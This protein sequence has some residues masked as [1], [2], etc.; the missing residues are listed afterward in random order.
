VGRLVNIY[1]RESGGD[2]LRTRAG[3]AVPAEVDTVGTHIAQATD[4]SVG[5]LGWVWLPATH[6]Y[7]V[8]TL[9]SRSAIG[10]HR[11]AGPV[12]RVPG[13]PG[14]RATVVESPVEL[15][16]VLAS[17]L[18]SEHGGHPEYDEAVAAIRHEVASS[19]D[20]C[21]RYV[22]DRL[23][24]AG[25]VHPVD[26]PD[27][28][29][30]A[31][32]TLAFGHPFHPSPKL[33]DG[34]SPEDAGD[35]TPELSHGFPLWWIAA[36]P[37]LV[38]EER[39]PTAEPPPIPPEVMAAARPDW[40]LLPCHPWQARALTC[41]DDLAGALDDGTVR[42]LGP[43]GPDVRPTSSVRTVRQPDGSF[44][45]LSLDVRITNF[46]RHN[47]PEQVR[48][49]LDA[50]RI[51]TALPPRL[52]SGRLEVL[53]DTVYRALA[54]PGADALTTATAVLHRPGP[55]PAPTPAEPRQEAGGTP[56][57][58]ACWARRTVRCCTRQRT[59]GS[60]SPT[61]SSS[62]TSARS[63]PPSPRRRR[64]PRTSC[65]RRSP[66]SCGPRPPRPAGHPPTTCGRRCSARTCRPRPT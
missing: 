23:A 48:R 13:R 33:A 27:P 43:L 10:H 30:A 32:A 35:Y 40:L 18:L 31:E 44:W 39:L 16:G 9:A 14:G 42:L 28:T 3:G 36:P 46:V 50:G 57:T 8:A 24:D 25:R 55:G 54:L 56:P 26:A 47:T 4:G 7:L 63:S 64:W 37:D 19:V 15:A 2:R 34:F 21:A 22:A 1:L 49:T 11:L 45:K 20:R 29:L 6:A 62:T 12:W 52:R 51:I 5:Q 61:T 53:P 38:A 65:G 59:P 41:R 60:A 58:G 17:E 66:P